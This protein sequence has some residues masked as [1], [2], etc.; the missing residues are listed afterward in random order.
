LITLLCKLANYSTGIRQR[1]AYSRKCPFRGHT[2]PQATH[3]FSTAYKRSDS[4]QFRANAKCYATKIIGP[5]F[6]RVLTAN[7]A[8]HGLLITQA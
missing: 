2:R 4:S 6:G 5:N 1:A 3:Y 7:V 8:K